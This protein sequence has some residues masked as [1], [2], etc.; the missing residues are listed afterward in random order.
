MDERMLRHALMEA[1]LERFRDVLDAAEEPD[2]SHR[3]LRNRTRLLAD[4]F[5]WAK[6]MAR[7]VWKRAARTAA[8]VLLACL[9][10]KTKPIDR[11]RMAGTPILIIDSEAANR[12]KICFGK[13]RSRHVP[14]IIITVAACVP[15]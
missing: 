11:I 14:P 4:P 5:G 3:Y 15:K 10:Q 8:C 2:W 6:R 7:P 13:N 1:N 12:N 9:A